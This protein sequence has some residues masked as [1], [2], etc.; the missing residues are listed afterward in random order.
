MVLWKDSKNA[1]SLDLPKKK[2][3]EKILITKIR[4]KEWTLL[5]TGL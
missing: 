5:Q 1:L 3:G 2:K 4:N